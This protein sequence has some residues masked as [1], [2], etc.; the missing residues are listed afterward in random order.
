VEDEAYRIVNE[1][2]HEI[3]KLAGPQV[4]YKYFNVQPIAATRTH[5]VIEVHDCLIRQMVEHTYSGIVEEAR[6]KANINQKIVFTTANTFPDADVLREA[7][8]DNRPLLS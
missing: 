4:Y 2:L 3:Y 8:R 7:L 1:L 5:L 6:R